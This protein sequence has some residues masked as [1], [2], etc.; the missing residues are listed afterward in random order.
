MDL[1]FIGGIVLFGAV[2]YLLVIGC[3]RLGGP[4]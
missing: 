2:T 1:L 4:K 3:E